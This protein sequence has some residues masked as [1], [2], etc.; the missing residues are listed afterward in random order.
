MT[1]L[2]IGSGGSEGI[3]VEGKAEIWV[4][5]WVARLLGGPGKKTTRVLPKA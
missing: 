4:K 1:L 3:G 2:K 5:V